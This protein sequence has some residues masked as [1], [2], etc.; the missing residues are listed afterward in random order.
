MSKVKTRHNTLSVEFCCLRPGIQPQRN[1]MVLLIFQTDLEARVD[2]RARKI[3]RKIRP[4]NS[5][6]QLPDNIWGTMTFQLQRLPPYFRGL[7][8]DCARAGVAICSRKWNKSRWRSLNRKYNVYQLLRYT[9]LPRNSN[10]NGAHVACTS[11]ALLKI[12][13]NQWVSSV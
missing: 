13:S 2:T 9:R 6:S 4:I 5:W 10:K 3:G 12:I 8:T 11:N 1:M 7:A